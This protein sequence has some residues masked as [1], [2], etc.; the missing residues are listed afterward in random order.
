MMWTV[1]LWLL[2]LSNFDASIKNK[3]EICLGCGKGLEKRPVCM[4]ACKKIHSQ[5]KY[6]FAEKEIFSR[7]GKFLGHG[8]ASATKMPVFSKL[9]ALTYVKPV[10][11]LPH[12]Q[13]G[14]KSRS[15]YLPACVFRF[16]RKRTFFT[17]VDNRYSFKKLQFF[18]ISDNF[19]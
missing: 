8:L 7:S 4:P 14:K 6:P 11:F 15:I 19:W 17:F 2:G 5:I 10:F 12:N 9:A 1:Q 13:A 3:A 18:S 16:F